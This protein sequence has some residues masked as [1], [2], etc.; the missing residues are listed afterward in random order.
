MGTCRLNHAVAQLTFLTWAKETP[1]LCQQKENFSLCFIRLLLLCWSPAT[2]WDHHCD[3]E[4]RPLPAD[5]SKPAWSAKPR[6]VQSIS[7]APSALYIPVPW[8]CD[9]Q[10][11]A[12]RQATAMQAWVH[13]RLCLHT[14]R[15]LAC[16]QHCSRAAA[17]CSSVYLLQVPQ[18]R[19][20]AWLSAAPKPEQQEQQPLEVT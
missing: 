4:L 8:W 14:L 2:L 9:Q 13:R 3:M 1:T 6:D 18:P 15:A 11:A 19:D 7:T 17:I 10:E 16:K 20:A 12:T 5:I